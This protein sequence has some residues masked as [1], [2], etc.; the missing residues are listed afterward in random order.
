MQKNSK[1]PLIAGRLLSSSPASFEFIV[2]CLACDYELCCWGV[3]F[4]YTKRLI[5][6]QSIMYARHNTPFKGWAFDNRINCELQLGCI[7][8]ILS[9]AIHSDLRQSVL[10]K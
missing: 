6:I 2:H 4:N 8:L 5:V 1:F 10:L 3:I 9:S 7:N